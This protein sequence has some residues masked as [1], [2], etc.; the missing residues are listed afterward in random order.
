MYAAGAAGSVHGRLT[1]RPNVLCWDKVGELLHPDWVAE[2]MAFP[3]Y[4]PAWTI[5]KGFKDTVNWYASRGLLT[6]NG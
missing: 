3:G 2:P 6:S 5:E 1:G 4:Q